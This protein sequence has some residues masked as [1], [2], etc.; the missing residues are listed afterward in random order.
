MVTGDDDRDSGGT[1]SSPGHARADGGRSVPV[2]TVILASIFIV[3][4]LVHLFRPDIYRPVMPRW[5][6]AHDALI[7]ISGVAELLGGA[8]LVVRRSRWY[9]GVGLIL[10]LI[11]VFPANVEMLR[12]YRARDVSS[13]VEALLWLRLPFQAVLIWWVWNVATRRRG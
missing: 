9:A 2:S 7:L 6:P 4:G 10:L 11:A 12:V 13:G 1:L 3:G 5:L 8:G